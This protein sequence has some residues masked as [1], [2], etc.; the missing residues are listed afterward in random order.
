[1]KI[2]VYAALLFAATA[3]YGCSVLAPT[4]EELRGGSTA[5]DAMVADGAAA[6]D[7][8]AGADGASSTG[9]SATVDAASGKDSTP[10]A[11]LPKDAPC[12]ASTMCCSGFCRLDHGQCD[13]SGVP[14]PGC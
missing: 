9:D 5:G 6:A 14:S 4:D 7:G 1:M 12:S 8:A 2:F 13:C 11:C 3:V 10:P